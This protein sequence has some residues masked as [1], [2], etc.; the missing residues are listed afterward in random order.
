MQL[1]GILGDLEGR[2]KVAL[3]EQ[4]G[5]KRGGMEFKKH[6]ARQEALVLWGQASI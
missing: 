3:K 6:T 5:K 2:H 1:S 4:I